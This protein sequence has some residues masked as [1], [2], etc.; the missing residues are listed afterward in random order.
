MTSSLTVLITGAN[1]GIGLEVAKQLT[2]SGH[3]I[4]ALVRQ[5]S[6]ELDQLGVRIIDG[7]DV[8]Q[9]DSVSRAKLACRTMAFD[10]VFNLAG[11]LTNEVWDDLD[12]VAFDRMM[13]QFMVNAL[14]PLR[15]A[16]QFAD[17]VVDGGKIVMVTSRMGSISDNQSGGRYGYRMSK[18]ALN[19]ASKSLAIDLIP[20]QIAVGIFHP[21]WVQTAMTGYTGHL[22]ASESARQLIRS[23]ESLTLA[24][25]GEF[26][27]VNGEPL[28]W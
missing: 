15:V 20:R 23:Y 17:Q 9:P 26:F 28:G 5:S 13:T 7:I 22:T 16:Q 12:D 27:H 21:G 25:S 14:G 18:A 19:A 10:A 11:L 6:P 2:D 3:S 1:R 24:T 8:T 4:V